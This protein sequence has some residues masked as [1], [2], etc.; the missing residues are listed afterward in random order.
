MERQ[1]K[2]PNIDA[3]CARTNLTRAQL[4]SLLG[5]TRKT[6]YSWQNGKSQIPAS[7]II[8]MSELWN[9]SADYLLGLTRNP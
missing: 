5:V 9:V 2:Y 3:E 7:A 4:A 6:I 1:H 8:T